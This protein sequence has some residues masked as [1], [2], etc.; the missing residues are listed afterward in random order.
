M[1]SRHLLKK[2]FMLVE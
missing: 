2:K 1:A